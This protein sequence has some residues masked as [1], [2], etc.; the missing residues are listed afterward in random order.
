[1]ELYLKRIAKR[2]TYT[3]GK[4]YVDGVYFC[5]TIEDRDRG[6]K[7]DAAYAANKRLKV[8]HETAIPTGRYQVTLGVQSQRFKDKKAYAFCKGYLP[9]LLN[10]P[11]F[12]GVLIHIGNTA[13]DSSGCILVGENKVKGQVI[14]S[15]KT[16]VKLYSRLREANGMIFIKIE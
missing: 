10:V 6:L 2:D 5:D 14:N 13:K 4:L 1:M 16:F 9:R 11:C 3:I 8:Q 7:Q 15:T 12:D